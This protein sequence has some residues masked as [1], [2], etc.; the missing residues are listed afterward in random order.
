MA[1]ASLISLDEYKLHA[2]INSTQFDDRL[3]AIIKSVSALVKTYCGR[4]FIDGYNKYTLE[5]L[6]QE[7]FTSSPGLVYLPEEPLVSVIEVA[8][9]EDLGTS[10]TPLVL[11]TDYGVNVNKSTVYLK[12]SLQY[13]G[14]NSYRIKYTGGYQKTPDDLRLAVIDLVDYYYKSESTPRKS[15]GN[16]VVEFVMD[17][18]MPSHIRRVLDLYRIVL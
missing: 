4:N 12:D 1:G 2:T 5:Y 8:Y 15:Q 11:G 17:A 13:W 18:G 7:F 3:T 16:T 14:P 9:S 6:E 10:Y